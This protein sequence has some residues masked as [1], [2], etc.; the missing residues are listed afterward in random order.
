MPES[1]AAGARY[2]IPRGSRVLFG[3]LATSQLTARICERL[4]DH[5]AAAVARRE[6]AR[7]WVDL[8]PG[9]LA[10]SAASRTAE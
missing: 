8:G 2:E 1:T 7:V 9:P 3:R 6:Q 4:G 5:T 10:A